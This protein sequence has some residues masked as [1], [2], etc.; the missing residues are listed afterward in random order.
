MCLSII[1]FITDYVRFLPISVV[2]HLLEVTDILCVLVPLIEEK[3]WIRQ[4]SSGDREK[5][6]NGK[7]VIVDKGEYSKVV[8]LEGNVWI[9]IYNLFMEPECRKKYELSEFRKSNLLRLRKYM[10]EILLDQIPNLSHMLRALE[11][12]SIM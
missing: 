12:L 9:A 4:N 5:Y 10:N 2:H 7:W 8:R 3:P 11:E 6:E 1:R